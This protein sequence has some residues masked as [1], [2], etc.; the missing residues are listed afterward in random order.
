MYPPAIFP[1]APVGNII[2]ITISTTAFEILNLI[3]EVIAQYNF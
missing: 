3:G 2:S 1:I